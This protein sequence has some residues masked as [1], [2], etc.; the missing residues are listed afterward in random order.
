M[1]EPASDV[2]TPVAVVEVEVL[3]KSAT[4]HTELLEPTLEQQLAF[5]LEMQ[6]RLERRNEELADAYEQMRQELDRIKAVILAL[7]AE[8]K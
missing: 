1:P 8:R 5:S 6:S 4:P 2:T 3:V 7:H